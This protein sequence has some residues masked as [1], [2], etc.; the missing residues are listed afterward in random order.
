MKANPPEI[1][2]R[3]EALLISQAEL[4]RRAGVSSATLSRIESGK[5]PGSGPVL[6]DLAEALGATVADIAVD[7]GIFRPTRRRRRA[8]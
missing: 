1:R 2:R 7:D 3:R 4:G 5:E 8:A 6:A